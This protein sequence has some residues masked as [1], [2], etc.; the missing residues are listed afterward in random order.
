[1]NW[2]ECI[3]Q[4]PAALMQEFGKV[5]DLDAHKNGGWWKAS[6]IIEGNGECFMLVA[7][8]LHPANDRFFHRFPRLKLCQFN[9]RLEFSLH[10][11]CLSGYVPTNLLKFGANLFIWCGNQQIFPK[12]GI[13]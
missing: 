9:I 4:S 2:I 1:M 6:I 13:Q 10:P 12:H 3:H 5:G 11:P 7:Y 8:P